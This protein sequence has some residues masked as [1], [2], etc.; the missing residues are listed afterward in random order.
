MD[1]SRRDDPGQ[2]LKI[3]EPWV[4]VTGVVIA[5]VAAHWLFRSFQASGSADFVTFATK[6]FFSSPQWALIL[7]GLFS[8]FALLRVQTRV[9]SNYVDICGYV[10][11][12]YCG[13][14]FLLETLNAR[15]VD[16]DFVQFVATISL[17]AAFAV[18]IAGAFAGLAHYVDRKKAEQDPAG[19]RNRAPGPDTVDSAGFSSD[20]FEFDPRVFLYG[21]DF[22]DGGGHAAGRQGFGSG[23]APAET[24]AERHPGGTPARHQPVKALPYYRRPIA[25]TSDEARRMFDI[26][27]IRDLPPS[28]TDGAVS[29][30]SAYILSVGWETAQEF[31]H[32]AARDE[33]LPKQMRDFDLHALVVLDQLRREAELHNMTERYAAE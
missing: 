25:Y 5:L 8:P 1:R 19:R 31:I 18:G 32:A 29:L 26:A 7:A 13:G 3:N 30:A 17:S 9:K 23:P 2:G 14:R 4:V 22:L 6:N 16:G 27:G 15:A 21:D 11:G 12:L 28:S 33:D 24:G 10:V 20:Y